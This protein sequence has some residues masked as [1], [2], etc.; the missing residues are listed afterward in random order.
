MERSKFF[1]LS[2]DTEEDE[3]GKCKFYNFQYICSV[4]QN[5]YYWWVWVGIIEKCTYETGGKCW[6]SDLAR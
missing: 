3:C 4:V 5:V 2:E 1:H 6:D